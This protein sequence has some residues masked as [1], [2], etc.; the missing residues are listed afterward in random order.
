MKTLTLW[1][2]KSSNEADVSEL[3][4]IV[5]HVVKKLRYLV[6]RDPGEKFRFKDSELA[7]LKFTNEF[8]EAKLET[9]R[10][11][12]ETLPAASRL[13]SC[14][15]YS[16][17]MF[18]DFTENIYKQ[19]VS[20]VA[21]EI[22]SVI[23]VDPVT[24]AFGCLDIRKFPVKSEDLDL[25]GEDDIRTLVKHFGEPKEA[26]NPATFR[27]NRADPKIDKNTTVQEYQLFKETAF[28]IFSKR[29]EKL[30]RKIG[31]TSK[32][33]KSTLQTKKNLPKLD[34]LKA[35]VSLMTSQ[36]D[37][38]SLSEMMSS[39]SKAHK[40]LF[41]N[42]VFLLE[43]AII[44]PISN[45]TIERLFSFLKLVKTKL[46]NQ[47]SDDS[48]DKVLR[49][50]MEGPDHLSDDQLE[51]LVNSFK[52]YACNLTKSGKIRIQI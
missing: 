37:D 21:D 27:L 41:P 12:V 44:C 25:F 19:F 2:Q 9:V 18:D 10:D 26:I 5:S 32:L 8:F 6:S 3:S 31:S 23:K 52:E 15:E 1:L 4:T 50:K 13:R 22:E 40:L 38:M 35:E 29:K 24:Q 28:E 33:I 34:K 48:L 51:T 42:V 46:R 36:L 39:L 11:L 47:I 43:V 45:A 49:I 17:Q 16:S 30:N 14:S 20:E 7:K